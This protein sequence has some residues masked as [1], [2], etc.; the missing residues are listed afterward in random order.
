MWERILEVNVYDTLA[1]YFRTMMEWNDMI[2]S[3]R[4]PWNS[5]IRANCSFDGN[6]SKRDAAYLHYGI[7]A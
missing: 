5:S 6:A 3:A 1:T 7:K 4:D 2:W